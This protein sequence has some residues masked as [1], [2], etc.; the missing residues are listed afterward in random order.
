MVFNPV[1]Y[2]VQDVKVIHA[3]TYVGNLVE[4][5]RLKIKE[6]DLEDIKG[7]MFATVNASGELEICDGDTKTPVGMFYGDGVKEPK[8]LT[9]L[10]R[11]GLF[12]V[13]NFDDTVA[14]NT[15]APGTKLVVNS[16]GKLTP[17]GMS[18][19]DVVAVVIQ[20]PA[21]AEDFLGIKLLV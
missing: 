4:G 12:M 10:I 15:F 16:A 8:R 5:Q 17:Q 9:I 14:L 19:N 20:Q 21:D 6:A 1:D 3:G 7:G 2:K 18:T 11:G 13:K